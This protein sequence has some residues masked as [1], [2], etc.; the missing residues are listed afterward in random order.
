MPS[1]TFPQLLAF[2]L[3]AVMKAFIKIDP[4]GVHHMSDASAGVAGTAGG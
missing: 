4:N 2:G 3:P 1:S